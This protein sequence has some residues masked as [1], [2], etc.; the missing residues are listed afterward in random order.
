[1][2]GLAGLA[3]SAQ[4]PLLQDGAAALRQAR[5][6]WT[7]GQV[8]LGP[9]SLPSFEVGLGGA[10]AGGAY[11]P[12]VG[13]EGLGHGTA[14][15]GLG[16]QG[17]YVQGGW[18]FS[19]TGLALR[20]HAQTLGVLHR[21]TLAYRWESGWR[22]A[23]EQAPFAWGSGLN[24][25]ALLG[26]GARPFP[27]LSLATPEVILPV[28][29]WRWEAFAG[30]LERDRP[31]PE[32]MTDREARIEARAVGLDLQKPL[33][34][35]GLLR[36][37]FGALVEA[38]LG[39]VTMEG[40]QAAKGQL[41]P[42]VAARTT[43]LAELRVRLPILARALQ[44]RGASLYLSRSATP[45]SR[46]LT[47]APARDL[48]G[49]QLVWDGWDLAVE[50]AGSASPTART[51]FLQPTYLAGFSTHG[52]PLGSAFG[53]ESVTRTLELGAPLFLEGQGRLKAVRATAAPGN[54][55]GTGTWFLQ[56]DAQWRTSTGRIGATVASQRA[57]FPSAT[58]RWG[59]A[60]SVF[61]A[62]RVF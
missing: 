42:S 48:G 20:H 49:L 59:W 19:A 46:A 5:L 27:R 9:S 2:V 34:W 39:T 47:L 4:A 24:G 52:D 32:W 30:W 60:C 61:Q 56:A 33:L 50:Y 7:L 10:D 25:G 18:S 14:G 22:A 17:R 28:S 53:P 6:D 23:L 41:A 43:S 1:M 40:G 13:S 44:A 37:S 57:D 55:T 3:A 8:P 58:P 36:A 51:A 35:G 38:S 29:R 21:A 16:L 45:E 15:W 12:L 54:F 62:F 31:I 26:D 11:T